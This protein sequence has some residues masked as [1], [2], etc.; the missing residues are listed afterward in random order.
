MNKNCSVNKTSDQTENRTF[1]SKNDV[2]FIEKTFEKL[3]NDEFIRMSQFDSSSS[4]RSIEK[5]SI[6]NFESISKNKNERRK[7]QIVVRK[8]RRRDERN[9][10]LN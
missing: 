4:S 6:S 8:T 9:L 10:N 7:N 2:D 1:E 5:T 3:N